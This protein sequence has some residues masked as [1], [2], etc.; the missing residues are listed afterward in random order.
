MMVRDRRDVGMRRS[1]YSLWFLALLLLS[2]SAWAQRSSTDVAV[3]D[4]LYREARELM[5]QKKY[6]EA[7]KKFEESHRLDPATGTLLNL[8]ACHEAMG[9]L[10]SAWREYGEAQL[11]ARRDQREDRVRYAEERVRALEARLSKLSVIVPPESNVDGLE[12]RLDSAMIG[13]AAWGMAAPIDG[14]R[15]KID[16]VAP[17]KKPWQTEITVRNEGDNLTVR[18]PALEDAPQAPAVPG[19]GTPATPGG[20]SVPP[21][22]DQLELERPIPAS[23]WVSGGL[24]LGFA[25]VAGITGSIYLSRRS[26]YNRVNEQPGASEEER[27]QARKDAAFPGLVSTIATGAAIVG[28]GVTIVLYATRPERPKAQVGLRP[29]AGGGSVVLSGAF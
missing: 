26:D 11:A 23:V 6:E 9:R 12:V 8:A 3:A 10:A 21:E 20:S 18:I 29:A 5:D 19:A 28:A 22:R 13:A 16:A 15:H 25:A 7:C 17:G 24:T 1:L 2:E 4:A 27:D 14:G